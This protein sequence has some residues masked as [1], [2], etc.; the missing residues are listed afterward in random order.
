M[1]RVNNESRAVYALFLNEIEERGDEGRSLA[2][3]NEIKQHAVDDVYTDKNVI[4]PKDASQV[5]SNQAQIVFHRCCGVGIDVFAPENE[6]V[7]VFKF[8]DKALTQ[9]DNLYCLGDLFLKGLLCQLAE[10]VTSRGNGSLATRLGLHR[11]LTFAAVA[12]KAH[13][14]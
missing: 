13:H 7:E 6:I 3:G 12:W 11:A 5:R 1:Q 8:L 9:A 10:I 4:A 2:C 14:A